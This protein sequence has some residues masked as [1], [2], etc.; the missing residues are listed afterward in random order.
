MK[1][2][3]FILA[4]VIFS[5]LSSLVLADRPLDRV[6]ILNIF[7]QLTNQPK[8]TW[9]PAGTIEAT[10]EE[11]RAP[12]TTDINEINDKIKEKI[13]AYQN[14]TDKMHWA[15]RKRLYDLI[16]RCV[17]E[18]LTTEPEVI[19]TVTTHRLKPPLMDAYR[20]AYAAM[21]TSSASRQSKSGGSGSKR[22]KKRGQ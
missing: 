11:Y 18:C 6:E 10:L 16:R 20:A 19:G 21:I 13:T 12:E 1:T 4:F 9:I 8:K 17:C 14:K 7:E 3:H 2:N 5:F 15:A 22:K